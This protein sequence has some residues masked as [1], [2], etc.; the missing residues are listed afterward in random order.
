[1]F[2]LN[3]MALALD[4]LSPVLYRRLNRLR[5]LPS[6]VEQLSTLERILLRG[7]GGS[8]GDNLISVAVEEFERTHGLVGVSKVADM[9]GLS[10]RQ[11][12]RRFRNSVGISPKL[13][14]RMQR[15]QRVLQMV[16]GPEATW[17]D[18]ALSCGYHDQAHLIRDFREFAGSTPLPS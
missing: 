6:L 18:T 5:E 2:Q 14:S 17:A 4:D 16:E 12:E 8:H 3:D 10:S 11:F 9:L 1:M 15:F 13:F 7:V